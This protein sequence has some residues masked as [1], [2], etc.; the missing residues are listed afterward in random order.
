VPFILALACDP[1]RPLGG[2]KP[3][4]GVVGERD[5]PAPNENRAEAPAAPDPPYAWSEEWS[6]EQS[7]A[8]RIEA[9]QGFVRDPAET[10][11]FS[12]WLRHLPLLPGRPPVLLHDGRPKHDQ[13]AHHAVVDID[14]G[15]RDL[16]QCADAVIR[17]RAEYLFAVGNTDAIHFDFTSG[18]RA[19][20]SRWARGERPVVRGNQV[21]WSGSAQP[22][23]SYASFRRYLD[24][25]F[26]Y[27]GTWSLRKELQSV[28][29]L[30]DLKI[31]DLFIQ[32]GGPGHVVLVVDRATN[33]DTGEVRFLLAQSYMPAQ[34]IHVL[35]NPEN[36]RISPW[37]ELAFGE[38]LVTPQW[39]FQRA[40]LHRFVDE[41]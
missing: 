28:T 30:R 33:P 31:G 13:S 35:R 22:D 19:D 17:L 9:P 38:F 32:G 5:T 39:T 2:E 3:A 4:H 27:A 21:R 37:Y 36:P 25:V 12:Y 20:W 11:S 26:N 18:D 14:V 29:N 8:A 24:T 34:Q 15:T 41:E 10:R 7:L 16:Q 6:Y 40:D 1:S 23:Y